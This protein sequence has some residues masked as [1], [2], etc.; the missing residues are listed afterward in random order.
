MEVGNQK[1][2]E[3]AINLCVRKKETET[4]RFNSSGNAI[5]REQVDTI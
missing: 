4:N 1:A 5:A 3:N 2:S